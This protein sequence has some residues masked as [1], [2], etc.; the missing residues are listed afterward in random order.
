VP[1]EIFSIVN[2]TNCHGNFEKRNIPFLA[3]LDNPTL[4]QINEVSKEKIAENQCD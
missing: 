2:Q 1:F 3:S 4:G